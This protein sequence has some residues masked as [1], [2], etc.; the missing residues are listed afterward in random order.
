MPDTTLGTLTFDGAADTDLAVYGAGT[1]TLIQGDPGAIV[2]DGAGQVK[3][4]TAPPAYYRYTGASGWTDDQFAEITVGSAPD[5][6]DRQYA[7]HVRMSADLA[8]AADYYMLR[9]WLDPNIGSSFTQLSKVVN[10]TLT[11]LHINSSTPWATGDTMR[12]RVIG[13][14]LEC[15]RNGNVFHTSTD[16]SLTTG[17]TGFG[18]RLGNA[19]RLD[20]FAAG[21]STSGGVTIGGNDAPSVAEN[22]TSIGT[23]TC[24][25]AGTW[26]ITG[27][28]AAA[29]SFTPAGDNLSGTLAF[30]SGRNFESPT[31]VGG[32]N[33]YNVT[34]NCGAATPLNVAV[35]VTNVNEPPGAPTG[36]A[37]SAGNASATVSFTP[38]AANGGPTPTSYTATS[39][40]GGIQASNSTS[41]ISVTGLTNG[42]A[43]TFT[44]TATNSEGTGPASAASNSVTP[45]AGGSPPVM[46]GSLT[47]PTGGFRVQVPVQAGATGYEFSLDGGAWVDVGTT[48]FRDYSNLALGQ[49]YQVRVRAYNG[50][51]TA[52]DP[53]VI[54]VQLS[55]AAGN[56]FQV[57]ILVM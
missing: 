9:W 54:N 33:V 21:N 10:G 5:G 31:D 43:Y 13:T 29:F 52:A 50:A 17:R 55:S 47:V 26:S 3:G 40:P 46:S 48:L 18:G 25:V 20:T 19:M 4:F 30:T 27:V 44:V 36:P 34:L 2:L 12:L 11:Q 1:L 14:S 51:G 16:S 7:V 57:I 32:N 28:D 45:S 56:P 38:P 49:T 41:P 23:Y 6:N 8:A 35:T 39:S 42:Q 22:T 15:L 24:S 37:A 53:L